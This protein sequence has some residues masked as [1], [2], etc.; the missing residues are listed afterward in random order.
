MHSA[1]HGHGGSFTQ[2][3]T[4]LTQAVLVHLSV[5]ALFGDS[6]IPRPK[7][8]CRTNHSQP[9]ETQEHPANYPKPTLNPALN[10]PTTM[11]QPSTSPQ[12]IL[13]QLT[14]YD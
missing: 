10:E 5:A 1:G 4:S 9:E 2:E 11:N 3:H 7:L 14:P 6:T 13:A 12:P 8:I